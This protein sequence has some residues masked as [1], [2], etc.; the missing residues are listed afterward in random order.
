MGKKNKVLL[1]NVNEFI[2]NGLIGFCN[3]YVDIIY[4]NFSNIFI[5]FCIFMFW[6]LNMDFILYLWIMMKF[7][8]VC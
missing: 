1:E 3:C 6:Y 4:V 7:Y 8:L 5:C 2:D